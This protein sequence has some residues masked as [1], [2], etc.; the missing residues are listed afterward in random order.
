MFARHYLSHILHT[1]GGLVQMEVAMPPKRTLY[2]SA[3]LIFCLK[4]SIVCGIAGV[5]E[6]VYTQ[7]SKRCLERDGSSSLPPGTKKKLP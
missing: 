1:I 7:H 6:L 4:C 2:I 3:Q 5:V